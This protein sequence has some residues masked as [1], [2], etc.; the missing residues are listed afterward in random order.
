MLVLLGKSLGLSPSK[1]P[2]MQAR[3]LAKTGM[4]QIT[5]PVSATQ[6]LPQLFSGETP[7]LPLKASLQLS[8]PQK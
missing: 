2:R 3:E 4:L 1:N 8:S 7:R 5:P 6:A